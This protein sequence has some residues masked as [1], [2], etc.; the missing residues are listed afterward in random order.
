MKLKEPQ[1]SSLP[2]PLPRLE[3]LDKLLAISGENVKYTHCPSVLPSLK[4]PRGMALV[5]RKTTSQL[6]ELL[7]PSL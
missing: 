2:T 5:L 4:P 6:E 3:T 7:S 1:I